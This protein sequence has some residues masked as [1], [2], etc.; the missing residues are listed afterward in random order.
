MSSLYTRHHVRIYRFVLRFVG[1]RASAKDLVSDTFLD[2]W[3]KARSFEGRSQVSTWLL[4]IARHKAL[5]SQRRHSAD[6]DVNA[7]KS[8]EDVTDDRE[9]AI[10]KKQK[11]AILID[12]LAKLS[13]AHREIIDLVYSHEK[14]IDEGC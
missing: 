7:W 8:I 11:N 10:E 1:D 2:V 13:P 6:V 3:Q 12:C 9:T 14:S 5:A 4:S